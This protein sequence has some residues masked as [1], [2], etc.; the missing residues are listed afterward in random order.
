MINQKAVRKRMID[1]DLKWQDVADQMG[2]A[3]STIRQKIANIRPMSLDEASRLQKILEIDDSQ[4]LY[5]FFYNTA[6]ELV[7]A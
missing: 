6:K 3:V 2:L 7:S 1:L 4:F 5:Y